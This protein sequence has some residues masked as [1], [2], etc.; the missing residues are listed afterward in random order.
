[1]APA[2]DH[3]SFAT[4]VLPL[5]GILISILLTVLIAQIRG[6]KLQSETT[7][8]QLTDHILEMAKI[9]ATKVGFADCGMAQTKCSERMERAISKPIT[10]AVDEVGRDQEILWHALRGH[11]HT[12]IQ[13][14]GDE[15][16]IP[17]RPAAV[18]GR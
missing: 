9:M 11:R 7:A 3:V 1:M 10:D 5:I 18:G 15:V 13:D 12:G 16:I 17:Q 14:R 2:P 4:V 8:R 6:L